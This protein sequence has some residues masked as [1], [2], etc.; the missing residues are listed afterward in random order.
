MWGDIV[1]KVQ[2]KNDGIL[3]F[4][5]QILYWMRLSRDF[6]KFMEWFVYHK[7]IKVF[8]KVDDN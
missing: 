5:F 7:R 4:T 2:S 6:Q 3:G 1:P 8:F